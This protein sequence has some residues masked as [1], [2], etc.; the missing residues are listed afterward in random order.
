ML[1][2]TGSFH[3]ALTLPRFGLT[4]TALLFMLAFAQD[5]DMKDG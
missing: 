3:V 4:L 2:K 5:E 1:L